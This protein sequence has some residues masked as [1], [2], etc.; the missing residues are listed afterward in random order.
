[1]PDAISDTPNQAYQSMQ[2]EA[3]LVE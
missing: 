3:T 1:V 2:G